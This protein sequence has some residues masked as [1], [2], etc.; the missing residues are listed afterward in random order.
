MLNP[1]N[2]PPSPLD[3]SNSH[4]IQNAHT[5]IAQFQLT[6]HL[7]VMLGCRDLIGRADGPYSPDY[8]LSEELLRE[9]LILDGA[10]RRCHSSST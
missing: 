7:S 6:D 5:E 4:W 2:G 10:S 8:A 1:P 3:E 9:L